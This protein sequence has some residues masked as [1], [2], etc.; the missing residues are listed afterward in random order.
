LMWQF[1]V[2]NFASVNVKFNSAQAIVPDNIANHR[3]VVLD[4]RVASSEIKSKYNRNVFSNLKKFERSG[5][6]I[7]N[8]TD[9]V[10]ELVAMFKKGRGKSLHSLD[11]KFY[12]DVINIYNAFAKRG[13][14]EA[15]VTME[16]NKVIAGVLLL[17][18]NNRLLN[19]F[20]ASSL[21]HAAVAQCTPLSMPS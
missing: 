21:K 12:L 6:I 18:A 1:L 13:E 11:D 14:A 9:C 3:N 8:D 19:F 16:D 15:W 2:K 10:A 4:L 17:N 5:L 20:T 7:T